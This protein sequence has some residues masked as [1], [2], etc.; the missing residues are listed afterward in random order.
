MERLTG[1]SQKDTRRLFM[2]G[3]QRAW[4]FKVLSPASLPALF[5]KIGQNLADGEYEKPCSMNLILRNK[6]GNEIPVLMQ[7]HIARAADGDHLA[8]VY[9]MTPL[10][11]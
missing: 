10:T 6:Y 5:D 1:Y 3:G 7:T 4:M 8:E 2:K 9:T 11:S